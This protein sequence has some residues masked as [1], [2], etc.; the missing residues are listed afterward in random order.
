[1][2]E[3]PKQEEMFPVEPK[4]PWEKKEEKNAGVLQKMREKIARLRGMRPQEDKLK[5]IAEEA[6]QNDPYNN[7]NNKNLRELLKD[8]DTK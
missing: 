7:P 8:N 4:E 3:A 2:E 1:M 6:R 5:N